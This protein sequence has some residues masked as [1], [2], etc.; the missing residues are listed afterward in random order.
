MDSGEA[1]A[2]VNPSYRV[3]S[4]EVL[5]MF[6]VEYYCFR[7]KSTGN[8]VVKDVNGNQTQL[9]SRYLRP[10]SAMMCTN[11]SLSDRVSF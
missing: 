9:P 6:R 2:S 1:L 8:M 4:D 5:L 3:P 11:A 7:A 10:K